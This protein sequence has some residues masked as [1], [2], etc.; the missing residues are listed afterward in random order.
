MQK[1]SPAL[2]LLRSSLQR[3]C[4]NRKPLLLALLNLG[5]T[6]TTID[7]ADTRMLEL[8]PLDMLAVGPKGRCRMPVYEYFCPH[9]S[10]ELEVLRPTQMASEYSDCP[11]C[12]GKAWR[13][14]SGFGSR[15]GSYLQPSGTPFRAKSGLQP[16]RSETVATAIKNDVETGSLVEGQQASL[17]VEMSWLLESQPNGSNIWFLHNWGIASI[18]RY[19]REDLD[20]EP[21]ERL[22]YLEEV[23]ST[24]PAEGPLD[25]APGVDQR[26]EYPSVRP[27]PE[28]RMAEPAKA[29]ES[30]VRL[31]DEPMVISAKPGSPASS[32]RP[33]P[34][35]R[36]T[37]PA[38][39]AEP[40]T[41]T[42][43]QETGASASPWLPTSY[44]GWF[45]L[46]A[47]CTA[48]IVV[49]LV[50]ILAMAA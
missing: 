36:P 34:E 50:W 9:C 33:W 49:P 7:S 44:F 1:G 27:W 3:C 39:V 5:S 35:D 26:I 22:R 10:R 15:T 24:R 28:E 14:V 41:R 18:L 8:I 40:E 37:E 19:L 23:T 32:V 31:S 4:L 42:S 20:A 2:I 29:M 38:R 46:L 48:A 45:L 43:S 6:A 12:G 13:L 25:Y 47:A 16:S 21:A 11:N 30:D 17:A